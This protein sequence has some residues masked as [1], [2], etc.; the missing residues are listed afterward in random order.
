[1]YYIT[2]PFYIFYLQ[3]I[4]GKDIG[5]IY[6]HSKS[7][8]ST[9][10]LK[11]PVTSPSESQTP[12]AIKLTAKSVPSAKRQKCHQDKNSCVVVNVVYMPKV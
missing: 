2:L 7:Q 4:V 8:L 5:R 12:S 11:A 10:S 6:K 9:L 1:M 3:L